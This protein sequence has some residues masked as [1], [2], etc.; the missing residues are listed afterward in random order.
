[1]I[2]AFLMMT[3]G[4][5]MLKVIIGVL[6]AAGI[7][8]AVASPIVRMAGGKSLAEA[9]NEMAS[10][11]AASKGGTVVPGT[12]ERSAEVKKIIFACDAGMGSSAMGATKFRN[13]I[14]NDRPDITVSN[15]SVDN[16]PGDCDIAVVQTTL[17][18]RAK[19]RS[20]EHTSELQSRFD[21]VCR[22]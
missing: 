4:P 11:K 9:Q 17:A 7:S 13:R 10:M 21:L 1:S 6:I 15:T 22:L 20:E 5:D 16:I 19:K 8:F 2:I 14:K 18:A 12:I 3:P